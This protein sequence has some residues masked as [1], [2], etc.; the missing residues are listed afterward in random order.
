MS[1]V[2]FFALVF[3][4]VNISAQSLIKGKVIDSYTKEPLLGV[5]IINNDKKTG[6]TTDFNGGFYIRA[7]VG[8]ELVFSYLGYETRTLNV[9]EEDKL[10][11]VTLKPQSELLKEVEVIAKKNIND[12]DLRKATGAITSIKSKKII[13]RPT[14]NALQPLQGQVAGLTIKGSG[15]VGRPLKIRIR[16]T[17]T[18]PIKTAVNNKLTN[19][20]REFLDNKANQPLFVL[21]GQIISA[22][23]F[24]TL[25]VNDI[26]EIKVLKDATANA[27]YGVKASNGIIE[28]TSKRGVNGETQYAFSLQQGVTFKGKPSKIMMGTEEKLA[29]ERL[30]KNR[31]T[32]GYYLSE[33][34]I[35]KTFN[36]ASNIE[37][38]VLDGKRKLDSI[39]KINTNWFDE[40]TRISTY[41]SYNL[42]TRG[43]ND[44]SK[45][46]VS[47]NFSKH[48]GKFDGNTMNRFTGRLNYEYNVSK[49][50]YSMFNA[51]FGMSESST[52]HGSSY[53]P[54][55]L[56]Y[57]LNPY[58][59]KKSGKLIS[60]R[61]YTF[62]ELVNQYSKSS[63]D[64]RFNFSANITAKLTKGLN[65][66][67][68]VGVDYVVSEAL[69]IVP[70]TAFSEIN[71]GIAIEERGSATKIKR[72]N[73]NINTN[74][75]LNYSIGFQKHLIS[76]SANID[77]YKNLNDFI[78]INGYGLPSKLLSGA[79]INNDLTGSKSSKTSSSKT[80]EATLGLGFSALYE[81]NNKVDIYASYKRDGSSLLPSDK[82]WNTFWAT[83]IGYTLS[84]ES[85]LKDS[86]WLNKLKFRASY[87]VTASLSGITPS[88]AVP[89]FSYF[90]NSYLGIREFSL[91]SLFNK[92]LRPEENTSINIGM[93][94]RL[95]NAFN[96][97]TEVYH[98]RTKD[99]LLTVSIPPTNGFTQ[100]LKNVGVMDNQGVELT[101][102][103]TPI[104]N[105]DFYWN[106][107]LTFSY[108]R[109]RV[110]DLYEGTTLNVTPKEFY[111]YPDY[112]EGK[113]SDI[114]YGLVYLGVNPA[115]GHPL[116]QRANGSS[117]DGVKEKPNKEDFIVLGKSTPPYTGGWFHNLKYKNWQLSVDLYYSFGGKSVHTNRTRVYD[118]EDANKNLIA[119]QLN[120]TWFEVGDVDKIYP[121]LYSSTN[122]FSATNS[123]ANTKNISSTDF[124]RV[125]NLML[126]YNFS[127]QMLQKM[128]N[129]LIK[130]WGMYAQLSNVYTWTNF[131]G[132]DP[133]SANLQGSAQ[134]ILTVGTNITF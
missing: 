65:L 79:G 105:E 128:S 69:S 90:S 88:Q 114:I 94:L 63:T 68:I 57:E 85:F 4:V 46:Y 54:A 74:T 96:L 16:G 23:A 53:S 112:Q 1:K 97:T 121:T 95:F 55:N 131:G 103:T 22:E 29:F 36:G 89:T 25:N 134:P 127:S 2:A 64:K 104:R 130:N 32:P 35:R 40:L 72:I 31:T 8:T 91:L 67:T 129:G 52:P 110:V 81:W 75:R 59:Q 33:E 102:N 48:G 24:A 17:S 44:S 100:Q 73:T 80:Q 132:G 86:A 3:L 123:I 62:K 5:T 84:N 125:N 82:R 118:V 7:K 26:E 115:D 21:D 56:I 28:I 76:L 50:I 42:S 93:D 41:Q 117:F 14:L 15:E 27:L 58:E 71:S 18:L 20:E 101:L 9:L 99:M 19:E 116:F 37:Q 39:K 60:Y 120:Q 61:G 13:N 38:L 106:T 34:Y 87:G 107:S 124:V 70:P 108:N 45:F 133:E 49:N 11:L 83:G 30:S 6:V 66:A 78:G 119:G 10:I 98:R 77:Y 51:G 113:P 111:S 47:G 43:G 126:R 109:N 12:I 122:N 92:N